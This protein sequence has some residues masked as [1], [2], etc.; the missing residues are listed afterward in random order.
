MLQL[1]H[2]SVPCSASKSPTSLSWSTRP[3]P[4]CRRK[5]VRRPPKCSTK[6]IGGIS[7]TFAVLYIFRD[8]NAEFGRSGQ[9]GGNRTTKQRIAEQ[10]TAGWAGR[11][12]ESLN[13]SDD[14]PSSTGRME[15]FTA[16]PPPWAPVTPS[17]FFSPPLERQSTATFAAN[18][19]QS[20]WTHP[21]LLRLLRRK[22]PASLCW[23]D[24]HYRTA[25]APFA[26]P[27]RG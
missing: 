27:P 5:L 19:H 17:G 21:P 8:C 2:P 26:L 7:P 3:P 15:K 20:K 12:A 14:A 16:L 4:I 6:I 1:D 22:R 13:L 25:A 23:R 10:R 11:A 9:G 18:R 24:R